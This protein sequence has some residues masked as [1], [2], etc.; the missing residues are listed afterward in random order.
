MLIV[1]LI[2]IICGLVAAVLLFFRFPTLVRKD[3]TSSPSLSI[4]IPARNEARNLP[5]ILADLENQQIRPTEII[6]VDDES[7]DQT[8]MI[9]AQYA[10]KV[11]SIKE[12]PTDWIGKSYACQKAAEIA[13]GDLILFLDADV[14]LAPDAI[15]SLLLKHKDVGHTI[16]V[17]PYHLME[18]PYEHFSLFF[19]IIQTGANGVCT[20]GTAKK[21]GLFG[22]VI[23]IKKADYLA[24][25]GHKA[26]Q[27]ILV[28]DLA[29]GDVLTQNRMDYQLL[30]GGNQ[31]KYRMY[32]DGWS[33]LVRGWI[34]NFASGAAKTPFLSFLGILA[35]VVSCGTPFVHAF[36]AILQ[37]EWFD[38]WIYCL[39]YGVW[40]MML[41]RI[42]R[43]LGNFRWY[44]LVF[45][46]IP[47]IFFWLVFMTSLFVRLF[48]LPVKW[49]DRKIR[50]EKKP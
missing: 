18:K 39:T 21:I 15:G 8:A 3:S 37:L 33:S 31:I 24:V 48:H 12:K 36:I 5:F 11:L 43:K 34:K 20:I 38:F 23:L 32:G 7:N 25:G 50:E 6:V 27:R 9:A 47:F 14:R 40:V 42:A 4:I 29:L 45:Y 35:F 1:N 30:L 44:S 49:K 17:Q 10:V 19:N 28:E 16:S 46:P 2:V 26:V 22:P 13:Q 41:S